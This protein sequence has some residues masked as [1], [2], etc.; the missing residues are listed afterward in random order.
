MK[1]AV[2]GWGS[3][4]W[5]KRCMPLKNDWQEG[6]PE[7][8]IEFSRVSD[9]RGGALTLVID[10][11]NGVETPTRFAVSQRRKIA[12]AICDLRTREGTVVKR[13]GY[14]N[15]VTG[16]QRCSAYSRAGDIVRKWAEEKGFD[17]VVWTDLPSNFREKTCKEFSIDDAVEYLHGL[18]GD[19]A[20]EARD[21]MRNAPQEVQTPVR[22]RLNDDPWLA[23]GCT[24]RD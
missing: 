12:D 18:K 21:Y 24:R 1:I 3:L 4:I 19:S 9:S 11:D 5:E 23:I 14:V 13:I 15:L 20:R 2:L 6:G 22:E 7:L 16:D 17:A 10:P 8:P